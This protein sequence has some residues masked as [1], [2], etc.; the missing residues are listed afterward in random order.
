MAITSTE[1]L[2]NGYIISEAIVL[3][4]IL[5]ATTQILPFTKREQLS[6][7]W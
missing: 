4:I 7:C 1:L 3:N 6:R 2:S 5:H